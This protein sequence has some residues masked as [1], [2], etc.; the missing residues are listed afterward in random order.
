MPF[1]AK[2]K[3]KVSLQKLIGKGYNQYWHSKKRYVAI[4]GSRGSKK[5]C[6]T[7]I[8]FIKLIMSYYHQYDIKPHLLVIRR[9]YN[10]HKNSTRAQL[11]WAINQLGV[12][13]LWKIP[14]GDNI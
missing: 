5:S 10:T 3:K 2:E 7:A 12:G 6:T 1:P 4:K 9:Y 11:V 8:R 13:H 14:K